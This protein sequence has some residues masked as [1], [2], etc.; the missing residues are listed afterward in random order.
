VA[1]EGKMKII[2]LSSTRWLDYKNLRLEAVKN[3]PQSFLD[4]VQETEAQPDTEWQNKIKN[5]FFA[6]NETDDLV[7]M[8]GVYSDKKI[9]LRHIANIV[10]VYVK[11]AYRGQ[12]IGYCTRP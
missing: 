7:G 5:M 6:V 1:D 9:K 10:S 4:T 8:L 3:S 11:P 12:G 2:Q